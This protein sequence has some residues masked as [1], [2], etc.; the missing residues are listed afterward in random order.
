MH[1]STSSKLL[2]LVAILLSGILALG[3]CSNVVPVANVTDAGVPDGMALEDVKRSIMEGCG[4]RGWSC[5]DIDDNTI[6]GSIWVRG[7]HFAQVNI[8]YSEEHYS[9]NFS[10]SQHLDYSAERNKI[11]KN[12][13]SWVMNLNGDIWR[14][15]MRNSS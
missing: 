15:L 6:Q 5:K 4:A 10:D 11:H 7:K 1:E 8:D 12:Y 14:A 3:G 9:I 2:W 13:N